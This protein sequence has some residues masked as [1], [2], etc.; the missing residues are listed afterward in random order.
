[1]PKLAVTSLGCAKNLVDTE[2]M[3]GRLTEAGWE[4]TPD[5]RKAELILVNT[6]GFIGPAKQESIDEIIRMAK[7]KKPNQGNCRKLVVAG[8]LVQRYAAELVNELPE[9]DAWLGL[10][11][12]G[13]IAEII[14]EREPRKGPDLSAP[15]F[16]NQTGLPRWQATLRHTTFIKAA[17][18]CSHN[19]AYCAIPLIK[20]RF[21]SVNPEAIITEVKRM[22]DHGVKE[23]NLIAQDL[24]MYGK[25]LETRTNLEDLLERLLKEAKPPWIRLLYAY[26][27]GVDQGLLKLIANEPN[28]CNYLDLPLQ[29][30]NARILRLMNRRESP[31]QIREKLALIRE[32]VPNITLRTSFIVGFPS[33]SEAEFEELVDF[34]GEG[35]FQHAGVFAYSREEG[36]KAYSLRP[37]LSEKVKEGRRKVL[38]ERQGK[39][40]ARFLAGQ[41][42]K[43]DTLLID[44]I[45]PDGRAVG[46]SA[47]FAPEVDGVIYLEKTSH[48]A[49]DFVNVRIT[50]SDV[51]N[52]TAQEIEN[53]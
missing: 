41:I 37:Q 43:A 23:F 51:Y 16:L 45:L 9:V 15:P 11:E 25:D 21:R 47:A 40:S 13:K 19:C 18:G 20:G 38:F 6:C 8:C 22:V 29:H 2:I 53:S 42:G 17:E 32:T 35:Y 48:Q 26:P 39:I 50:G 4:V 24:T 34:V 1:M 49:G 30:I 7:Y 33:E 52:L 46:R 31:D 14:N 36:T 5:F 27:S 10:G 3:L 44:A 12:I 28:I